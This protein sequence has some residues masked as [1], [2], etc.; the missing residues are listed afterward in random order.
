MKL[1]A[2]G[3]QCPHP[4]SGS[5]LPLAGSGFTLGLSLVVRDS[6]FKGGCVFKHRSWRS[7]LCRVARRDRPAC[8]RLRGCRLGF[9]RWTS[10]TCVTNGC[11]DV[12]ITFQA[13][14][15]GSEAPSWGFCW[16][17]FHA[18]FYFMVFI[19]DEG[20]RPRGRAELQRWL[21]PL[22]LLCWEPARLHPAPQEG[23]SDGVRFLHCQ[24]FFQLSLKPS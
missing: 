14:A 19:N 24:C 5:E 8:P 17:F 13:A 3:E 11:W 1:P 2:L 7:S 15:A 21:P 18:E 9:W 12:G 22:V 23:T 4:A 20:L 16:D 6:L 10:C